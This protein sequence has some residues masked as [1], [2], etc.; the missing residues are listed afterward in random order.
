MEQQH[1]QL[2]NGLDAGQRNAWRE[3]IQNT[4]NLR[5]E[6]RSRFQRLDSELSGPAPNAARVAEHAREMEQTMKEWH[7]QYQTLLSQALL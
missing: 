5:Q 3:Q 2:M 4:L 1:E 7:R 6:T